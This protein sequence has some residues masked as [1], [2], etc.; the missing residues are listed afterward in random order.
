MLPLHRAAAKWRAHWMSRTGSCAVDMR[1]ADSPNG[2]WLFG[3]CVPA[4]LRELAVGLFVVTIS[5]AAESQRPDTT[6]RSGRGGGMVQVRTDTSS[7]VY[8]AS[9]V[10]LSVGSSIGVIDSATIAVSAARTLSDL[11]AARVAGASVLR[12]S[13]V[14][15]SGSRV[16]FR[17]GKQ[18]LRRS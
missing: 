6:M 18:L 16:R 1:R 17:G 13:G 7:G 10:P 9:R 2:N 14:A 4:R 11:L 8:G 15:G 3:C 5:Q 12:S